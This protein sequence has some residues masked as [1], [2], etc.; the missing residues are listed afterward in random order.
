[1][2]NNYQGIGLLYYNRNDDI[3]IIVSN[4]CKHI[5]LSD[6]SVLFLIEGYKSFLYIDDISI[7]GNMCHMKYDDGELSFSVLSSA[8]FRKFCFENFVFFDLSGK[9]HNVTQK[10][11]ELS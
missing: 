11:L 9:C 6:N 3:R 1:M 4:L 5:R 10:V 2:I 8:F 7:S